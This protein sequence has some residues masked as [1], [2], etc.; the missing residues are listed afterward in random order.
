M[1]PERSRLTLVVL[2]ALAWAGVVASP[3]ARANGGRADSDAGRD[4]CDAAAPDADPLEE[5]RR[6]ELALAT[7]LRRRVPDWSPEATITEEQTD[8]ALAAIVDY[9]E[10]AR[11]ALGARWGTFDASQRR[12]FLALFAPLTNNA[13]VEASERRMIVTYESETITG[14]EAR[15]VATA[16]RLEGPR[17]AEARLEYHLALRCHRWFV[18]DVT[19]DGMSSLESTRAQFARLF[20]RGSFDDV[21]AAM[22]RKVAAHAA[23]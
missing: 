23:H 2:M 8:R 18:Y 22:R 12:A 1:T 15:V 5:L 13:M 21:L 4:A 9:E 11:R 14:R 16:R 7:T 17:G 6:S 19:V 20:K 3:W 10:I